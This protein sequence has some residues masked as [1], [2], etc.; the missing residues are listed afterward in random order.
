[1]EQLVFLLIIAGI[2]ELCTRL[3]AQDWWTALTICSA[4]AT[5]ALLG[6]VGYYAAGPIEGLGLGLAASGL[7]TVAGAVKSMAT[8]RAAIK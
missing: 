5:G 8:S 1:M 6:L 4:A 7:V 3:R 2:V